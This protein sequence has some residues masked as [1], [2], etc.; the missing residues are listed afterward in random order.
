MYL[1]ILLHAEFDNDIAIIYAI[2]LTQQFTAIIKSMK[3][4][5]N[6][7]K[8]SEITNLLCIV[9]DTISCG[10]QCNTVHPKNETYC[11]RMLCW[12]YI[13]F[14]G[15]FNVTPSSPGYR[16]QSQLIKHTHSSPSCEST[17][18]TELHIK[19]LKYTTQTQ[20]SKSKLWSYIL[21]PLYIPCLLSSQHPS[22]WYPCL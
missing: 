6:S 17:E 22:Q 13:F 7:I 21:T 12:F 3:G 9:M 16:S 2:S 14:P 18:K 1:F 10:I 8:L 11:S 15:Y 19:T 4:I 20:Q 5:T